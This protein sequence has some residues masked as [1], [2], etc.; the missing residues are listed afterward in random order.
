MRRKLSKVATY[1]DSNS[2]AQAAQPG[3]V[4]DTTK[5]AANEH[6]RLE[7]EGAFDDVHHIPAG[8]KPHKA[9]LPPPEG[10]LM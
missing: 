2:V 3:D 4:I 8:N 10:R 6:K 1:L 7:D 5:L 9:D